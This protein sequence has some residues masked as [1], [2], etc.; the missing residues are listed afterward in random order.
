MLGPG[1]SL[2]DNLQDIFANHVPLANHSD[3][4]SISVQDVTVCCQLLQ[5]NLGELHEAFD[6]VLGAVE[7]F[8]AKRVDCDNLDAALVAYFHD[9]YT[10]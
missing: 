6:F 10:S 2:V 5:L 1:N 3:A 4:S 9:L 7:V 8:D